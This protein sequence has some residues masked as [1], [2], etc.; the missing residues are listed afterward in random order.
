MKNFGDLKGY[1]MKQDTPVLSFRYDGGVL[2]EI[3]ILAE[4]N[5]LPYTYRLCEN[6][7][8]LATELFMDDRVVPETR[9]GLSSELHS[10]GIPYYDPVALIQ[11][12]KGVSI[13]DD[14]WIKID[15]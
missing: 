8:R 12:N 7:D 2:Q 1:I 4:R 6:D 3:N 5:L 9:Q 10:I 15:E 13:E 14:Y 11:Y